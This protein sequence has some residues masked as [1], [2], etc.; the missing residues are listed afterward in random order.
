[1]KF[2]L[3]LVGLLVSAVLGGFVN[4]SCV[5]AT[6]TSV[7]KLDIANYPMYAIG[8]SQPPLIMLL[9]GK[10]QSMYFEAYNDM[11]DLDGDG[12]IDGSFNPK[13]TYDG[14]YE[15]DWCYTYTKD[16]YFEMDSKASYKGGYYYCSK[17]WSGNFLNYVTTSRMD[18]VK[19]ILIGGQRLYA[20]NELAKCTDYSNDKIYKNHNGYEKSC[21]KTNGYPLITRQYIPRDAH[22]WA[23]AYKHG[24]IKVNGSAI[25]I[26][27]FTPYGDGD[28]M[29]GNAGRE[30]LV[31][32]MN[33]NKMNPEFKLGSLSNIENDKYYIWHWLARESGNGHG[34]AIYY[35]DGKTRLNNMS[36]N[37]QVEP[38]VDLF[39]V[40]VESCSK[41]HSLARCATY[42]NNGSLV[43]NT[44]GLLQQFS[45]IDGSSQALFGLITGEWEA[46]ARNHKAVIRSKMADLSKMIDV[47]NGDFRTNSTLDVINKLTLKYDGT[48]LSSNDSDTTNAW[49]SSCKIDD[50]HTKRLYERADHGCPDWGNPLASL[51]ELSYTYFRSGVYTGD[52]KDS[53]VVKTRYSYR[54]NAK[55]DTKL[56]RL[57]HVDS[58]YGDSEINDHKGAHKCQKPVNLILMDE[59]VSF[60]FAHETSYG[61]DLEDGYKII[62]NG[63]NYGN[64]KYIFGEVGDGKGKV[65]GGD[66]ETL[67][68]L[69][70]L[71]L[72]NARGISVLEPQTE[73]SFKGPGLAAIFYKKP[74]I[75]A[76]HAEKLS[77]DNYVV[78][79]ASNLP[80]ITVYAKNG[81]SVLFVPTCKSVNAEKSGEVKFQ[82]NTKMDAFWD[83]GSK[84][85]TSCGIVDVF[86]V[87]SK[88][89][90]IGGEKRLTG[91][92]FRVT[93]E[94]NEG[95]SD[96]DMDVATSYKIE[97]DEYDP[98]IIHVETNA[99]YSDSFTAMEM[100]FVIVGTNGVLVPDPNKY[101][102]GF[103][104]L[105]RK[106]SFYKVEDRMVYF[107]VAKVE[108]QQRIPVYVVQSDPYH[109]YNHVT[110]SDEVNLSEITDSNKVGIT[111]GSGFGYDTNQSHKGTEYCLRKDH[112]DSY[113][114][115]YRKDGLEDNQ[116]NLYGLLPTVS[117]TKDDVTC[118]AKVSRKF[119]VTGAEGAFLKSP[120][121]L[122]A[123]YGHKDKSGNNYFY[124][125]NASTL[126]DKLIQAIT[127]ITA[128]GGMSATSVAFTSLSE[129]DAYVAT[130]DS[131]Y[132]TSKIKKGN[133]KFGGSSSFNKSWAKVPL[134]RKIWIETQDGEM[135]EFNSA[136]LQ[137]YDFELIQNG[138]FNP[139]NGGFDISSVDQ[140]AF[141]E[142]Y[143]KYVRGYNVD[144]IQLSDV[145][146]ASSKF[147][148]SNFVGFRARSE[149]ISIERSEGVLGAII[150]SSPIT[151]T[152]G[153]SNGQK[154]VI[155]AANDGMI[156]VI[157]SNGEVWYSIIPRVAQTHMAA[158][159]NT[160]N[161]TN[162][163]ILDGEIQLQKVS[164]AQSNGSK[165]L[166]NLLIGSLGIGYPGIYAIDINS[167]S[168]TVP[169]IAMWDKSY[170]SSDISGDLGNIQRGISLFVHSETIGGH[171]KSKL[172]AA[173]GNGYNSPSGRSSVIV[174]NAVTGEKVAVI[175]NNLFGQ[176][177][178]DKGE[179]YSNYKKSESND[180]IV[181]YANGMSPVTLFDSNYDGETDRLYVGD[182]YG[183][184]YRVNVLDI[185]A[186]NKSTL[187]THLTTMVGP[188]NK[189]QPITAP[190][191]IAKTAAGYPNIIVGTGRYLTMN[192]P[193]SDQIQSIWGIVDE[194]YLQQYN[195]DYNH[196][197]GSYDVFTE[198]GPSTSTN[199]YGSYLSS[200]RNSSKLMKRTLVESSS[201]NCNSSSASSKCRDITNSSKYNQKIV[202]G[203]VID[204]KTEATNAPAE[205][206]IVKPA[207]TDNLIYVTTFV[208]DNDA[209]E[210]SSGKGHMYVL[211]S[212]YGIFEI[213]AEKSQIAAGS[214]LSEAKFSYSK[215]ASSSNPDGYSENEARK[216]EGSDF[217]C[218]VIG[219][220]VQ[221][222]KDG[223]TTVTT[224]ESKLY[225]PKVES[226]QLIYD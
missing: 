51:I 184:L 123:L 37:G 86:Y 193:T 87:N 64:K 12:E 28:Y 209:C 50:K 80:Q 217:G 11:V 198:N 124:V 169:P 152:L 48:P 14:L 13:V 3:K 204:M 130:F 54:E 172:Y 53:D 18:L 30:M 31:L 203:W 69:K 8:E 61:S 23:K 157:K 10:D 43:Y 62:K 88:Y 96:Y 56:P 186:S 156:H 55:S 143:V 181:C 214:M 155:V 38:K 58:P 165:K 216:R 93:Y 182:F 114:N 83:N 16:G 94:D 105:E 138:L 118:S 137:S 72:E 120:L 6:T 81:K 34:G 226:W 45:P 135:V 200:I 167:A 148:S 19:R 95:G 103:R 1:M 178:C 67:P 21:R 192:D 201:V 119:Y 116:Y 115:F 205:R 224:V 109:E 32:P 26:S 78:S 15:T 4:N 33:A 52:N 179:S 195:T 183:N 225:C 189:I 158:Y 17:K 160:N 89:K 185:N 2:K 191:S 108:R 128:S 141:I 75:G 199:D 9:M 145:E 41:D 42:N 107:D 71:S 162:R 82:N 57:E 133:V 90:T 85:T 177:L 40:V 112:V 202:K 127:S 163:Y 25:G 104:Q 223:E 132:W 218:T 136:N 29:F 110:G 84:Y 73:G 102:N 24:D 106:D 126:G 151:A 147:T 213:S 140:S 211:D 175:S 194:N 70:D 154:V 129:T 76:E 161:T 60:D 196:Y 166:Y 100:G 210:A 180:N 187:I 131:A 91:I 176:A 65:S 207:V 222:T 77:L 164:V 59:N 159:A 98:N 68:T 111:L 153:S 220:S 122:T 49:G 66:F 206:V 101:E 197:S 99:Y 212:N 144:E 63:E 188:D 174:L 121:E 173:F 35:K 20:V 39:N 221:E 170:A 113:T 149:N 79:M 117:A 134:D 150:N 168:D 47:K 190:V 46:K 7:E 27:N 44:V 125:T 22:A 97:A 139:S 36:G 92:E 5:A 171:K 142:K 219:S 208:P 74:Q 146:A 215:V